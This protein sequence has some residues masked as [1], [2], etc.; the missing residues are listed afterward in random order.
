MNEL[1]KAN[2]AT[3][4]EARRAGEFEKSY[5]AQSGALGEELRK[6][7]CLQDE[8]KKASCEEE[9]LK[10]S[11]QSELDSLKTKHKRELD[12]RDQVNEQLQ[13]Q[14][15]LTEESK[16]AAEGNAEQSSTMCK[17]LENSNE[18]QMVGYKEKNSKLEETIA[19]LE[20]SSKKLE[21]TGRQDVNLG[22]EPQPQDDSEDT[23]QPAADP[24]TTEGEFAAPEPE[25]QDDSEVAAQLIANTIQLGAARLVT[26]T[27]PSDEP[28]ESFQDLIRS[29]TQRRLERNGNANTQGFGHT[30]GM[31]APAPMSAP[32]TRGLGTQVEANP[33]AAAGSL[34][35]QRFGVGSENNV[36]GDSV[37]EHASRQLQFGSVD[38]WRLPSITDKFHGFNATESDADDEDSHE[39]SFEQLQ[40]GS[41]DLQPLPAVTDEIDSFSR[42]DP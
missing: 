32:T 9:R 27:R 24:E 33:P 13:S 35:G 28:R 38:L 6:I 23:M 29:M 25:L 4:E 10:E 41:P 5:N 19:S 15:E 21:T 12:S 18:E 17:V 7:D 34:Q 40:R 30:G 2:D 16:K 37:P 36:A 14:L 11:H 42:L 22:L 31:V 8:G 20:K 1:Q 3:S 26:P 39:H